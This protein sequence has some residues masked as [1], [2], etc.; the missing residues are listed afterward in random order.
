MFLRNLLLLLI[1]IVIPSLS[2]SQDHNTK[3]E[4]LLI[5]GKFTPAVI[6]KSALPALKPDAAELVDGKYFRIIQF[7]DIPTLSEKKEL[8]RKGIELIQYLPNYAFFARLDQAGNLS[9]IVT[10]NIRAIIPVSPSLKVDPSLKNGKVPDHAQKVAGKADLIVTCFEGVSIGTI[11]RSLQGGTEGIEIQETDELSNIIRVRVSKELIGSLAQY[12][13]I[14]YIEPVEKLDVENT[15]G[16]S[17]H[18]SN[19]INTN[20]AGGLR[21]DGTGVGVSIGD[22]PYFFPHVDFT[23]RHSGTLGNDDHATHV[24]GI[25]G[26]AGNI[27]PLH[28]GQAPGAH[29]SSANYWDDIS[30]LS[31]I[32]NLY[33]GANKIR[34]TNHS[35]GESLNAGYTS[36]ARLSDLEVASLPSLHNVHS[37]GNSGSGFFTITGGYKA[38]KNAIATGNLDLSDNIATSSSRGPSADGRI[39]PDICAKGTSVQSTIPNNSYSAM[40]GTS[41]AS[42]GASGCFAQLIHAYRDMNSGAD[43]K[44]ALLKGVVLNTAQ[45]LGN[46]G[47]DYTY[48][49]GRINVWKAYKLLQEQRYMVSQVSQGSSQTHSIT[50]PANVRELKVMVYWAD[51]AAAA[52]VTKALINDLDIT[53]T[54]NSQTYSPWQLNSAAPSTAAIKGVDRDNNMEQVSVIS[55]AAGSYSLVVNGFMVPQGP[56]EYWVTYEFVTDDIKVTYPIGGESFAPANTEYIRWDAYGSTGTFTLE[57]STNGGTSW[58]L[59]S[60]T[61]PGTSRSYTWTVPST[62]TGNALIRVTRNGFTGISEAPFSIIGV[63]TNLQ[64]VSRCANSFTLS[65][66]GVS[67][68]TGYEVYLLGQK[69]M[70]SQG[71]TTATNF[72]VTHPNTSI[73]WVSVRALGASGTALGRRAIAISVP[74]AISN[75]STPPDANFSATPTT[76]SCSGTVQFTDQ[77]TDSPTSW[78]WNF[79][80]GITS[81]LQNPLYTYPA[82]GTYT[83][84]LRVSNAVGLDSLTRTSYITIDLSSPP[85]VPVAAAASAVG[86]T[87]FTANWNSVAGATAYYLDVATDNMFTTFVTGYNNLNVGTATTRNITGLVCEGTYYYRVRAVNNCGTTANSNIITVNTT[88]VPSGPTAAAATAITGTS[89]TANW[90]SVP[91][92]TGYFLDVSTSST[93]ATFVTGYNNRNVGTLL[94]HN[95]TGLSC[96]TTYYYRLRAESSCGTSVNSNVISVSTISCLCVTCPSYDFAIAPSTTWQQHSSSHLSS[97][98]KFYQVAVTA[99]T[100]YTAKTGCGDGATASYDSYLELYNASCTYLAGDDDGCPGAASILTWTSTYTGYA[101]L[102]VRGY[103]SASGTYTLAYQATPCAQPSVPVASSATAVSGTGFTANWMSV[104]GATGYYLDVATD[105]L[106][107]SFLPGYNNLLVGNTLSRSITG[108]SCNTSYY[109][110]VRAANS[111]ATSASSGAIAVTTSGTP[112]A[113]SS[114]AASSITGTSFVA[115][116][117]AVTGATGYFLDVATDNTFTSFVTGYN[118]LSVGTAVSRSVTGLACST[119]YYYRVRAA[120]SCGT[121]V[122]SATIAA[123][124]TNMPAAPTASAPSAITTSGFTANWAAVSGSTGYYLDIAKDASFTAML[125]GYNNLSVGNVLSRT[126][127]GLNCGTTYYYRVRAVNSCGTS[128]NSGVV[129]ALTS[130]CICVTCPSYDFAITPSSAWQLHSSSH[131]ASGCKIYR[132][133][134]ASGDQYTFKTGCGNGAF[135]DYDTYIELYNT[136]CALVS[137]NDDGCSGAASIITWT[138][139]FTGFAYLKV[140]AYGTTG[141]SYTLAYQVQ[142]CPKPAAPSASAAINISSTGFTAEWGSVASATGYY[143][144]IATDNLFTSF[145]TGYNNLSVGTAVSYNVQNLSCGTTYYYRVRA[146]NSCGSG[147]ASSVIT[148]QTLAG[149]AAPSATAAA[150]VTTTGFTANWNAVTGALGYYLDV[151]TDASFS[152][153]LSSYNNL[154]A[155]LLTSYNVTGL[156][157]G[158]TYYYRVRAANSCGASISSNIISV[159]SGACICVAC[160]SFNYGIIP[161]AAWQVHSAGHVQSGCITYQVPVTLGEQYIFKTGCGN[162][163]AADYDTYIE[164]TNASCSKV[165]S[166]DDGCASGASIITW[167]ATFTGDAYLKVSGYNGAGG[168]YTLAFQEVPCVITHSQSVSLCDGQNLTVGSSTYSTTGVYIDTLIT[169]AGCDSIVTSDLT[170][171]SPAQH[172]IIAAACGS[173][174][175]N[176]TTYTSTGT[177]QQLLTTAAGCDSTIILDLDISLPTSSVVNAQACGNYTLNGNVYTASGTYTQVTA[178]AMG[179]DST[180]TLNLVISQP[181]ASTVNAASCGSYILNGITYTTSG[182]YTQ[183]VSNAAGCDSTITLTL[184]INSANSNTRNLQV[185]P[186]G[187]V[188]VGNSV[189]TIAGS[190]TDTLA[191]SNGCDSIVHTN[192]SVVAID[193]SVT[194]NNSTL[195]ANAIGA[196]YLWIDCSTNMALTGETAQS[197]TAINNGSYAV[198]ITQ[199]SCSDTSACQGITTVGIN[200]LFAA[201]RLYP[202][203]VDKSVNIEISGVKYETLSI[204]IRNMLGQ[205]MA[206]KRSGYEQFLS[207]SLEHVPSGVYFADIT[208]DGRSAVIRIVKQ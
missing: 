48:G 93:F 105:N 150:S 12:P 16:R 143:L 78:L 25:V 53:L 41:M 117:L 114:A 39:K 66:T 207:I 27:N 196:T 184:I 84:M 159:S 181:T 152:N 135:A 205:I 124:T 42:P 58:T 35:L 75:C 81:T 149:P 142:S 146:A 137:S 46:T 110:R 134:V 73:T 95:V 147:S 2:W 32:T 113:P 155:G 166:N 71:T 94:S 182:T 129:T 3:Y 183:Q 185:C 40:T 8:E 23:G 86:G 125:A 179:C 206:S 165:S 52:G 200:D 51:P 191:G 161:S 203:P 109:Y 178:N 63:P 76:T 157:C 60:S 180:I 154:G 67:G 72:V 45:D 160:P 50:V 10:D 106:F 126:V 170:M 85:P 1:V 169:A 192:L 11:T 194:M 62:L 151:A 208:I 96:T 55:P 43:P 59:I 141:G 121:S 102:K 38:G 74:T 56:Q 80:N 133:P 104:S 171:N 54:G 168:N 15:S 144:D 26:G 79:G 77:S 17:L 57:Y 18:R 24:A 131:A 108:L 22:G 156:T 4:I 197:F 107:T 101:Y 145:V 201:V 177:Y 204:D 19:T 163:A 92:A 30:T 120:N 176:G 119:T 13:F 99:G 116:W 195:T 118:N 199:N 148:A 162:G 132:V 31:A 68:A 49:W 187:S 88:S 64:V 90:S 158:T 47:P 202:N 175:L 186:G 140:K 138:A 189:Y 91:G 122:S 112:A 21:F 82:A 130:G 103:S 100:Q 167:T 123:A 193:T 69:Y 5:P 28:M 87:T 98:C 14:Q 65:W 70:E 6:E 111:C 97:G 198:I 173:Y 44:L 190:Y 89:F 9:A 174:T 34:V 164:L 33:N 128:A 127:T 188:A 61:V 172:T 37:S 36:T 115:N 20:I 139:D 29:L 7:F 83:V 136:S 153:I